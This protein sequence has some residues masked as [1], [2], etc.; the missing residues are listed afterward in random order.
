MFRWWKEP[1]QPQVH[2]QAAG[3]VL[4]SAFKA[5]IFS[6]F[7]VGT[8]AL[9]ANKYQMRGRSTDLWHNTFRLIKV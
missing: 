6:M 9:Q 7:V 8:H 3:F 5:G 4:E 2:N 1:T